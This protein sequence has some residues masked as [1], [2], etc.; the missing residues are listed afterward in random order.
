M[1]TIILAGGM[2]STI[3]DYNE[4]IPKPMAE[5]GE[6]PI[7]WHI[8]KY[9]A[10]YGLYD[11]II[12]GGYK[13]EEI[14]SYFTDYYLYQSDI[15]VDLSNNTVE[16][17][18]KRTENWKVTI[19]DTGA[20]APTGARVKKVEEYIGEED[21]LVIY[22]DCIADIDLDALIETHQSERKLVTLVAAR[23]T[24][25][26][27][28]LSIAESGCLLSA[29]EESG[30]KNRAWVNACYLVMSP[31]V[32]RDLDEESDLRS[33]ILE[34]AESEQVNVYKHHGFWTPIETKRD[35]AYLEQ[36]IN[37][38]SAPWIRW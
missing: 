37:D 9:C 16:V 18:K 32:F 22:G 5:I 30:E 11:F 10:S 8:M 27:E 6:Q 19:A 14:K 24:G 26:N 33:R 20:S 4:G 12:C 23:P 15:T 29:G 17:H 21:F 36:M 28:A 34:W 3:D 13:I 2:R 38:G 1:K 25:R 7:L 31:K 35:K